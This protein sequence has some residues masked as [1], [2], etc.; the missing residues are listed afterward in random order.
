MPDAVVLRATGPAGARKEVRLSSPDKVV[1]P[2]T[3]RGSAITKADLAAYLSAVV[4][5]MVRALTD[6]PVTLQRVRG[7]IEGEEFYSKNP[8]KGVP[9]WSRTTTRTYPSGRSHPQLVIDDEATLLWTA[10]MGTVTWHPWP[11]RSSDND[12]P[13]EIR[14]D[15]DPEPGL[16]FADIVETARALREVMT[17]AGLRPYVKTTGSRGV[18]V[19]AA[20][21]P[22]LEFLEVRHAVIGLA[23]ELERGLPDLV[24][25]SWWKEERGKRVFVDFN[26]ATRDRTLAAAW[27]PRILPGAPVSVPMTW[28]Q[29]GDY[30]PDELTV[31]EVPA[32][33]QEHGD[34]WADLH[35]EPGD[36]EGAYALWE[37]DLER[38]L[39]ELNFPPDHPKMPGEP[40]RV[41]PSK[42]VAANWDEHGQRVEQVGHRDQA[43]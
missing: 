30:A 2:A 11:V 16:T 13:D 35:D 43:D 27:S 4:T 34:A 41:Q 9:E 8:P 37:A 3:E 7:G 36:V 29:L 19:F 31:H 22:R 5:P 28:E 32:W 40:P 26:Q 14:I 24:T 1:W 15:L 33:L 18:H 6:R 20:I 25:T 23:R 17:S 42:K 12:H 10:Q 39:G 21:R 38:G